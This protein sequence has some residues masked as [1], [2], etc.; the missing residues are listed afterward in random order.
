VK[1]GS[2]RHPANADGDWY[3][4]RRCID[5][6]ASRTVAPGLIVRRSDQSVFDHQPSS[7]AEIEAAWRAMLVCP[8]ASVRRAS[9]GSPPAGLYPER[10][11]QGIYRC[12]YNAK[13]SYGAHSYFVTRPEGNVLID[14]P[15]LTRHVSAFMRGQGGLQHIFLTHRDDVADADKYAQT[16]QPDV[17]IHERDAGAAAYATDLLRG[18]DIAKPVPGWQAIPVPG[19]TAGSVVYLLENTFLFSGDSLAWS[20][21]EQRLTAFRDACWHSW[22]EQVTSLERLLALDFEWV[23]AG[24][25]GSVQLAR[26]QM[27]RQL[28]ALVRWMRTVS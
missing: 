8:T 21:S 17:W 2:E 6:G 11:A 22:S 10:L 28:E 23:L 19:H 12:G 26:D 7:P 24:H 9:G 14:A 15:R 5:C 3:V 13:S 27:H 25:G 18:T 1:S 20:F 16:F 4:D